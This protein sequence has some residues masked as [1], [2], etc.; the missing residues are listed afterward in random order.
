MGINYFQLIYYGIR[1]FK[2][3][4]KE[5]DKEFVM[6]IAMEWEKI[7]YYSSQKQKAYAKNRKKD[8]QSPTV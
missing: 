7:G 8:T 4:N 3:G 6:S 5:G 1:C 2:H